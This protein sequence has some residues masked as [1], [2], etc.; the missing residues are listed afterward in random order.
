MYMF[1]IL[2]DETK[3]VLI[4]LVSTFK[5]DATHLIKF[6]CILLNQGFL[7]RK[8]DNNVGNEKCIKF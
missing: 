5:G 6:W 2:L 8:N 7:L 3:H 1:V 4:N